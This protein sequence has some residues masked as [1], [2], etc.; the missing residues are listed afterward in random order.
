M[1]GTATTIEAQIAQK[2]R[3]GVFEKKPRWPGAPPICEKANLPAFPSKEAYMHWHERNGPGCSVKRVWECDA[4][5]WYHADTVAPDP[6]GASSGTG[7]S[8]K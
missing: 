7:R 2:K 1:T 4:C 6:A 3:A 8:N 5:G